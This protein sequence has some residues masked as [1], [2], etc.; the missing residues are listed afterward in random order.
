MAEKEKKL[1][2]VSEGLIA[3]IF[4]VV[5]FVLGLLSQ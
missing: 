4:F 1:V 5:A 3:I 2:G